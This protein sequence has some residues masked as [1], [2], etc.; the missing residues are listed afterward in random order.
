MQVAP[1]AKL[2]VQSPTPPFVGAADASQVFA[3]HVAA[4]S[5][6]PLSL[7]DE[8]PLAVKAKLHVG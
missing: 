2:S 7:H 5:A 4:V 3:L 8:A 1:A 6:F